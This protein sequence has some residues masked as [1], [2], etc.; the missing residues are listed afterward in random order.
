[1]RTHTILTMLAIIGLAA[2]DGQT[3]GVGQNG[4]LPDGAEI[5]DDAMAT[6]FDVIYT[7][8]V[9]GILDVRRTVIRDAEEWSAFWAEAT[10]IMEPQPD[11]PAVDF[12]QEMVIVAAMGRRV[13]GG[14]AIEIEEVLESDAGL[15]AVVKGTSPGADCIVTTALTAPVTAVRVARSDDA[16]S[17]EE[18]EEQVSCS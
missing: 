14:Y 8:Q 18:V 13:S 16:V 7:A 5:P 3:A 9:S 15:F 10:S 17:F 12:E 6:S 4:P 11:V 2:C 1:M